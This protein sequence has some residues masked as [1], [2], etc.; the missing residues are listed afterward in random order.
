MFLYHSVAYNETSIGT[1]QTLIFH[2]L[3]FIQKVQPV[4]SHI[5]IEAALLG[6]W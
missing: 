4:F 1:I 6:G 3:F 2:D 5:E